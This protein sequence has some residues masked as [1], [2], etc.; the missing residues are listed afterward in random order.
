[1]AKGHRLCQPKSKGQ[2]KAEA[3]APAQDPKGAQALLKALGKRPLP[4]GRQMDSCDIL[5]AY[6]QCP[7]LFLQIN[8]RQGEKR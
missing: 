4:M 1:M 6:E 8:L 5:F 7:M 3:K 2:T